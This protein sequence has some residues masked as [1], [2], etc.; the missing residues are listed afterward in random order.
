MRKLAVIVAFCA[1]LPLG[2][3]L[4]AAQDQP[5]GSQPKPAPAP[6]LEKPPMAAPGPKSEK[7]TKPAAPKPVNP[8]TGKVVASIKNGGRVDALGWDASKKLMFI[9]NGAEGNVMGKYLDFGHN[10]NQ[11][12]REMMYGWFDKH[13]L[14][15]AGE[16][17]E[18]PFQPIPPKELS[19]Y[20]AEHPL[21]LL[22]LDLIFR[23]FGP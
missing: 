11:V 18:Q 13:L 23:N 9:P 2:A 21:P 14:G 1:A 22:R 12:S 7:P 16:V 5:Q 20:D 15:G 8:D 4:L 10:Y 6:T 17:H 3:L 19:V